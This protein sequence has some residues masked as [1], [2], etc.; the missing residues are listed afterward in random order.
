MA[1]IFDIQR[2]SFVDGPGI[3]TT[4]FFK[5]CNLKCKWCQN[6]EG[7]SFK[8]QMISYEDRSV[9]CGKEYTIDEVFAE[10][11]KDK[12]YYEISNGGV[13]FSGGECMLQIDFLKD[14]LKKCKEN[15]VHTA[16]DTAGNVPWKHFEKIIP[17]TDLFL[18]DIKCLS[19]D[20]HIE[21]TGSSNRLILDNLKMLSSEFNGNI[22]IR[23][24]IINGFNNDIGEIQKIANFLKNIDH[25]GIEL[26]PYHKMGEHKYAALNM[27]LHVYGVPSNKDMGE[28]RKIL[29]HKPL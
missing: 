15:D 18:Y 4:V 11:I 6:P 24:P 21:G 23:I 2:G 17:Y 1:I 14:I 19:E 22:I 7:Q 13:T 20:L 29:A 10:I 16:V 5:N 12:T 27:P 26:L 25:N 8:P 3:R 28:Y 9:L